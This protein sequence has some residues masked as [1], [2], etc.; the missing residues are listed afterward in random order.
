[1][2]QNC[3]HYSA[4]NRVSKDFGCAAMLWQCFTSRRQQRAEVFFSCWR[5]TFAIVHLSGWRTCRVLSVSLSVS[6]IFL[7]YGGHEAQEKFIKF[8]Q[9]NE[10]SIGLPTYGYNVVFYERHQH[11]N[12]VMSWLWPWLSLN[13]TP[14][15]TASGTETK[16]KNLTFF[17]CRKCGCWHMY[18]RGT[19]WN[20]NKQVNKK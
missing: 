18:T 16:K 3:A 11:Y 2:P 8:S 4:F 14:F 15:N 17:K 20:K 12:F 13:H 7:F 9:G 10:S 19:K 5:T 1:M 6:E